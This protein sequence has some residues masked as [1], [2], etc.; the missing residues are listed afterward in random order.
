[1]C[2][3]IFKKIQLTVREKFEHQSGGQ[4]NNIEVDL[5]EV[6]LENMA[7]IR[8][9]YDKEELWTFVNRILNV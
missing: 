4:E 5:K 6:G 7:W 1:V 3:H 9:F 2:K 8:L